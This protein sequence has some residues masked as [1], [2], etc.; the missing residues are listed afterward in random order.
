MRFSCFSLSYMVWFGFFV[1][2]HIEL[3]GL[4]NAEVIV[5]EKD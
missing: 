3:R 1:L 5:V 2:W 4:F